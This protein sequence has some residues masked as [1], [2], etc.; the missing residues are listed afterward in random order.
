[1]KK[2]KKKERM[3]GLGRKFK[4]KRSSP[5]INLFNIYMIMQFK[6]TK[7]T[8]FRNL[9]LIAKKAKLEGFD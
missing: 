2:K 5:P 8:K 4:G 7:T 3:I 1:M 9:F 6:L